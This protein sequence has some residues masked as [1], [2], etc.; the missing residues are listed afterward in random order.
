MQGAFFLLVG[1]WL[2]AALTVGVTARFLDRRPVLWGLLAFDLQL[3]G[4]L[5]LALGLRR[6]EVAPLVW[7]TFL[8]AGGLFLLL[9][10][11]TRWLR[12][13]RRIQSTTRSGPGDVPLR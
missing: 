9:S 10:R 5:A 3:W 11:R 2:M 1:L 8:V 4:S 12:R 13:G 6:R 7:V